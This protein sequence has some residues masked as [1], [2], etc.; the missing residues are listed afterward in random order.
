M[1][2]E[3][4]EKVSNLH[5]KNENTQ[6]RGRNYTKSQKKMLAIEIYTRNKEFLW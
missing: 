5:E 3:P 1:T 6:Q 4:V 2:K